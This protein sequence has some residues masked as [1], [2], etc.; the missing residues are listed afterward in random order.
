MAKA[1]SLFAAARAP[2]ETIEPVA[3]SFGGLDPAIDAR[4]NDVAK[5]DKWTGFHRIEQALWVDE[6]DQGHGPGRRQA[7]WPT[8]SSSQAKVKGL[9]YQPEELANGANGLL[10]EV[11]AS[12]ITGEEDRYSHTDLSDFEANV[13][14]LADHVRAARAGAAR[15]GRG[16]G[17]A[18]SQQRFDAVNAALAGAQAGRRA[19][20]A[21]TTVGQGAAAQAQ[22]ARRRARRAALAGGRQAARR[23][24]RAALQ[25]PR[26]PRPRRGRRRGRRRRRGASPAT[27]DDDGSAPRGADVVPFYGAHQAGIVT[28][29]QDRLHMAAFDVADGVSRDELRDLLRDWTP[30]PRG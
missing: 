19:T 8:S 6:L 29:A 9:T 3:E 28:P 13:D 22:P 4:V 18:R 23:D 2:Y 1:K 12:K 5:G 17:H 10:D 26:L 25:P 27:L 20:R 30:R 16:A 15:E 14:G 24:G 11:S 21:T 7:A